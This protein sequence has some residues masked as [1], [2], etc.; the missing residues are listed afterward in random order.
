MLDALLKALRQFSDPRL[1]SV[2]WLGIGAATL[3]FALLF[4]AIGW[5]LSGVSLTDLGLS[6]ETAAMPA[7][8][9][10]CAADAAPAAER[11]G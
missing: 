11:T 9:A 4:W 5:L 1:R 7:G 6:P 3:V 8:A 10:A 2:V